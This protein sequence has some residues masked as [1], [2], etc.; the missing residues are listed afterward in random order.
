M[1]QYTREYPRSRVGMR[2]TDMT[3][4]EWR[5]RSELAIA[6]MKVTGM[7]Q[8]YETEFFCKDSTRA[9]VLVGSALFE[10]GGNEGVSFVMDITERKRAEDERE[11]LRQA[12]G[13]PSAYREAA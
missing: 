4:P 8:P 9:P 2:W 12:A 5:D 6:E 11:R 7:V 13:G 3:P 10:E 1:I